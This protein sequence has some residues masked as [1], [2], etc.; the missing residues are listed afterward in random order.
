M[1]CC[2]AVQRTHPRRAF[3]TPLRHCLM[4]AGG[5]VG[6]QQQ[7]RQSLDNLVQRGGEMTYQ[8]SGR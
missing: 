6:Q 1:H 4:R 8:N 3:L 5:I 7:Q 2:R